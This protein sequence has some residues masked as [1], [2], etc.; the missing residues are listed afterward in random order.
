[1]SAKREV[2]LQIENVFGH[3][4]GVCH[5]VYGVLGGYRSALPF[6]PFIFMYGTIWYVS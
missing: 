4:L 2:V 5:I 6:S 1:M 3:G